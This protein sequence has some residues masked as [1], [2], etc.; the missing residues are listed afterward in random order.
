MDSTR[1]SPRW[2]S[3]RHA[4]ELG[5]SVARAAVVGAALGGLWGAAARVW[6][7]LVSTT[8]EFSWVGSLAIVALAAVLGA[9]VGASAAA[10]SR[11]GWPRAARLA[12]VPGMVIF[13]GQ[14]IPFLAAF[15]VGGLLLRRRHLVARLA[16]VGVVAG[17]A[18]LLWWS[19]RLDEYTMLSA[20]LRVQ[21]AMLVGFPLLATVLA[22]AGDLV[23]GR[24]AAVVPQSVSPDRARSSL[25]SDSS[26]DAPAGPA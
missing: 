6:M 25:L 2:R 7:R 24:R 23:W 10:R 12:V 18:V 22:I 5:P 11:T 8:P 16:T 26:L 15:V 1:T 20:P 4:R 17:P 19:E 9:G 13:A 3:A 21:V 14:G